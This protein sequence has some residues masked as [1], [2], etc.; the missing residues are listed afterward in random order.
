MKT[1]NIIIIFIVAITSS[2][3][4]V[5]GNEYF[6][7]NHSQNFQNT[8]EL[9]ATIAKL[10]NNA[11]L[12]GNIDF[13]I[14]AEM[15][16]NGVVHV[17]THF[18][19]KQSNSPLY[20]YFYGSGNMPVLNSGSG[21]IISNDGYII[22][23]NHVIE[24]SDDID[25]V[26][27]NK[28]T[29]KAKIIGKD[30][31]T[32]LALLKI[33]AKN[34]LPIN[35]GNSDVVRIGEWVLAVGNPF[36]LTSTVTAGI[37]S[38]KGRNINILR[39][40]PYS[41][42]SFIQTD[43][44]VNP[45]NSGGALVNTKGELI[46]INTAI[47]SQTGS[48]A[49]Y[50]FAIPVNIVKKTIA[51]LKEF[52]IVQR[53]FLG[54]KIESVDAKIAKKLDLDKIEG[55]N[56]VEILPNGSAW[57]AGFKK[58][59]IIIKIADKIVNSSSELQEQISRYRPGNKIKITYKRD[60]KVKVIYVTLRNK[61]GNTSVVDSDLISI[62]GA[63]FAELSSNEKNN[64]NIKHGVKVIDISSGKLMKAGVK[65]GYIITDINRIPVKTIGDI[66]SILEKANGGVFIRGLYLDGTIEYYAFGM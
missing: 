55:V 45:G 40:S 16:V 66:S 10:S 20:Q 50:S 54:V 41:I 64:L 61:N 11:N 42:E 48:Y 49:G 5:L 43:A 58:N 7:K 27:N 22:T 65:K 33:D 24:N 28:Q 3:F 53:A 51:D 6:N 21:V 18:S 19:N 56:L 25:V 13:T 26:L 9:P 32:D 4:A 30:P 35:Y 36:N 37:I 2:F 38:A 44:V 59:D 29:F 39:D 60:N 8:N 62:M 34:L 14:A 12:Q 52:G 17:K 23:N 46:G 57:K 1:K 47:A 15:A 31:L 63:N